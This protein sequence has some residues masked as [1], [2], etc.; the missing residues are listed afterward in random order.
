MSI[1]LFTP[2]TRKLL[3]NLIQPSFSD[4]ISVDKCT[5]NTFDSKCVMSKCGQRLCFIMKTLILV[6]FYVSPQ[7][8]IVGWNAGNPKYS[9]S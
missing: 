3:G 1:C 5:A 4:T 9:F 7:E 6:L 2:T 8:I